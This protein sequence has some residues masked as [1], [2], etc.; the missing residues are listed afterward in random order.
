MKTLKDHVILYD[1]VCPMCNLYTKGFIEAGMLDQNGRLPYQEIPDKFACVVDQKRFVNEIALVHTPTGEVYYGVE[2]LL[3]IIGH[4]V[5]FLK[6]LFRNKIFIKI[7]DKLYKFISFNRRVIV[8]NKKDE[9]CKTLM[10]P[11]FHRGYRL[12][13]LIFTW[14]ATSLIL[15][16][17]SR[18]LNAI[19]PASNFYREF[20]V[21]G[22][23]VIWQA[24]AIRFVRKDSVWDYLG[25]MMTI[26]FAGSLLLFLIMVAG[27]VFHWQNPVF[28]AALFGL[29]VF[30]MLLEHIRRTRLLGLNNTVTLSWVL[31]RVIV[32]LIILIPVYVG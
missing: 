20:L 25:N 9:T 23:Q 32:L 12:A 15:Y 1:A 17:Y 10:D 18:R 11:S 13:Y 7:T 8:P 31:Y 30:C 28:F 24:I 5:P 27:K 21:C 4:S 22:G 14:M 26:S 3:Q 19:L 6:P 2:S 29:V 16:K